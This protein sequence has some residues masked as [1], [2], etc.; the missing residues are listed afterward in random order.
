MRP[1]VLQCG[2]PKSGNY[3]VYRLLAAILD[4]AG[5]RVSYKRRAG[6]AALAE[7]CC[8]ET[9]AFPEAAEVD[10]FTFA[11]GACALELQH[12]ECRTLPVDPGLLF[13]HSTLLWTHDPCDVA[14]RPELAGVSHRIYVLRDGRDVVDSLVHHVT[15]PEI[16]ALHPEYALRTPEAVYADLG[17]F[18]RYARRWADHVASYLR[19][20][21]RF[22]PVFLEDLMRDP[23]GEVARVAAS[24]GLAVDAAEIGPSLSFGVLALSAPGHLRRGASGGWRDSFR[25]AHRVI[26]RDVAGEALVALG[27]EKDGGWT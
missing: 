15:R 1:V 24:L 20:R 22:L 13:R 5:L 11:S 26:F 19:L 21:E 9:L 14:H 23:V 27:Y 2:F 12:P 10:S 7:A 25:D 18:E 8:A 17:L 3:G 4:A 16:L 6:I